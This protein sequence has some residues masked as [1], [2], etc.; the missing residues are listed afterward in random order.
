MPTRLAPPG[1]EDFTL[2]CGTHSWV[3]VSRWPA[4]DCAWY[5]K[6]RHQDHLQID[7][8]PP[9]SHRRQKSIARL[10]G[11]WVLKNKTSGTYHAW[12]DLQVLTRV[13]F[14]TGIINYA[15]ILE[16]ED[17]EALEV[18]V[19]LVTSVFLVA[20]LDQVRILIRSPQ[21]KGIAQLPS[22]L[23]FKGEILTIPSKA[24]RPGTEILHT[25]RRIDISRGS[26]MEC[27]ALQSLQLPQRH[28]KSRLERFEKAEEKILGPKRKRGLISR[29]FRPR[30]DD[31]IF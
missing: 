15:E 18:L 28:I 23:G 19:S 3:H 8:A 27:K 12:A 24:W 6:Q 7:A 22:D 20:R 16:L 30:I 21:A 2:N 1:F 26:W 9:V 14:Q 10:G 13:K 5:L 17:P 4:D 11:S 25:I 29:I 31:A